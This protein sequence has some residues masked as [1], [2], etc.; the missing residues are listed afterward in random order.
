MPAIAILAA[1]GQN[2]QHILGLARAA[3]DRGVDI[4]IFMTGRG[5]RHAL[6]PDFKQL[7]DLARV[8]FCRVSLLDQ[9]IDPDR[10]LPG[11]DPRNITNQSRHADLLDIC[12]RYLV[13]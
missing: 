4:H 6:D 13:L 10:D 7:L 2:F 12:D 9:G 5:V 11:V 8:S 1:T 3:R